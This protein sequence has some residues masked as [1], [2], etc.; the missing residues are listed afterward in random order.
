[1]GRR[2]IPAPLPEGTVN[3]AGAAQVLGVSPATFF[4]YRKEEDFPPPA[5]EGNRGRPA[6]YRVSDLLAW[7]TKRE[8]E[9][10]RPLL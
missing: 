7:K 5:Q 4:R 8:T 1:M 2:K 3:S 6:L 10:N 9:A